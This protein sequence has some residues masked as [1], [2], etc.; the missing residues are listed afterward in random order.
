MTSFKKEVLEANRWMVNKGLVS[1]TWGNLSYCDRNT[2]RVYIKPS[3]VDLNLL[4][5]KDISCVDLNGVLISGKSPSVDLPTHLEIY[6]SFMGICSIAHT[7][8]KYATIFAQSQKSIPCLGTTHA[9]YFFGEI[10][11]IAY[12]TTEEVVKNYEKY[13]GAAIIKFYK[14]QDIGYN[15]IPACLLAGHGPFV[16]GNTVDKAIEHAY[17]LELVAEMAY[18]TLLLNPESTLEKFII[19]KHFL[20]KH[21]DKG[22]YGQRK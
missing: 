13:T 18:K 3:G 9:D 20:R 19:D 4:N 10:P 15:D 8:S 12:P 22:Y 11:C 5:E 14:M 16:W 7:H 17:V 6:K 21:G 1:M 2:N